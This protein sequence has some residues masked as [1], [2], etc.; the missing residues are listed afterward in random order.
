MVYVVDKETKKFWKKYGSG[1]TEDIALAGPLSNNA[2]HCMMRI[3]HDEVYV[4]D[5]DDHTEEHWE[6]DKTHRSPLRTKYMVDKNLVWVAYNGL[7]MATDKQALILGT[8]LAYNTET[9]SNPN[10]R[11]RDEP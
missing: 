8:L 11:L 10:R 9:P 1:L 3:F 7:W 4:V 6:P 5:I 2:A